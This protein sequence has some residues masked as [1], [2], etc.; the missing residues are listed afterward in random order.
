MLRNV[1]NTTKR[2]N[3]HFFSHKSTDRIWD[4]KKVYFVGVVHTLLDYGVVS[5]TYN[6]VSSL[7]CSGYRNIAH[8][9][10]NF[11]LNR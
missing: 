4:D 9:Q 7:Y 3:C 1:Y 2:G 10:P 5:V 8:F 6:C 11:R